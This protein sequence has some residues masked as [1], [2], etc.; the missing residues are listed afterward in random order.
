MNIGSFDYQGKVEDSMDT[1]EQK[2]ANSL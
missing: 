1:E 2:N